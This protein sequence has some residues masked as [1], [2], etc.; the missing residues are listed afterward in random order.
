[1]RV[2]HVMASGERGGGAD[3]LAGLLPE[4]RQR[5]VE[6]LAVVGAQGPLAVR[7]EGAGFPV[8]R[9][10]LLGSR[11]DPRP[12]VRLRDTL[13][14][15][16]PDLVH[17]HGTRAAWMVTAGLVPGPWVYTVHGLSY[18]Q[19]GS[20]VRRGL[21]LAAETAVCR[22]ADEVVSVSAADIDDLRRRRAIR[23]DRGVHIPNAVDTERFRPRDRAETR[24]RLGIAD[25]AF[26]VGTVARLV[27]QKGV[28]DLVSA[29]SRLPGATLVV[30][31]DGPLRGELERQAAA[32][33]TAAV[34]LGS[35]DGV[36]EVL[37]S[38]D[39]F[40]LP[41][42]WEGEPIALLEAMASGLPCVATATSGSREVLSEP[43]RGV[44]V[45]LRDPAA[46]AAAVAALRADED[47]CASLGAAAR[48]S[49]AA[50][51]WGTVAERLV[52]VYDEVLARRP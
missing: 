50:R 8:S 18:R 1:M 46:I 31:G 12:V 30:V 49:V 21:R 10:D 14:L 47:R 16:E 41:S 25:D 2:V 39:V 35:R 13:R 23:A 38:F 45:P 19:S 48:A 26:V 3:H 20:F 7:L 33:G 52:D 42:L 9:L 34:F 37:P 28:G 11:V 22:R 29:V 17:C 4:L 44:L 5:G 27:T 43:G 15:L 51:T 32:D 24:R 6:C 40:V 36:E